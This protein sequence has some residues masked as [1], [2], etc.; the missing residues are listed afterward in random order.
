MFVNALWQYVEKTKPIVLLDLCFTSTADED[1][2]INLIR[3]CTSATICIIAISSGSGNQ[4]ADTRVKE[5]LDKVLLKYETVNFLPFMKEEAILFVEAK[6]QSEEPLKTLNK[7]KPYARRNPYLLNLA[8]KEKS[9]TDSCASCHN[10]TKLYLQR[11]LP[12][13][14]NP[15]FKNRLKKLRNSCTLQ[16]K[17]VG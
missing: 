11:T 9:F 17:T 8:L 14:E 3:L 1:H 12:D 16:N 6:K 5:I 2:V 13:D 10:A 4:F 15:F 7:I